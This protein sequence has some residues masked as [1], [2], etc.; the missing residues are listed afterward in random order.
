M[1]PGSTNVLRDDRME[2]TPMTTLRVGDVLTFQPSEYHREGEDRLQPGRGELTLRVTRL[3]D[4]IDMFVTE[5]VTLC[6]IEI[7]DRAE[8]EEVSVAVHREALPDCVS[9]RLN[10]VTPHFMERELPPL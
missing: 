1:D 10:L 7:L 3:P 9:P 5:W 4:R 6:G 2:R 8:G